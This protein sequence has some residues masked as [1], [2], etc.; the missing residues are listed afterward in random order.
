[1]TNKRRK[2]R[3]AKIKVLTSRH[4]HLI[5]AVARMNT[6]IKSNAKKITSVGGKMMSKNAFMD[7]VELEY[8]NIE[9]I[10]Y[11]GKVEEIVTLGKR[12][13][14]KIRDIS[15]PTTKCK[16]NSSSNAHDLEHSNFIFD[17]SKHLLINISDAIQINEG[18]KF[19]E[20]SRNNGISKFPIRIQSY[21]KHY[22]TEKE[23][24]EIV[25]KIEEC[26]LK[27]TE[28]AEIYNVSEQTIHRINN[29]IHY[30]QYIN[31]KNYPIKKGRRVSNDRKF[32]EKTLA[33]LSEREV[34]EIKD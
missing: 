24:L 6:L 1:M 23:V 31:R 13:E 14:R 30:K 21:K 32:I 3:K 22:L 18:L 26:K 4:T 29:G 8:I 9:K 25:E 11:K 7:M 10:N 33:K 34:T 12:G 19:E 15:S 17:I 28:I 16:Y 5:N 20:I 2:N 27:F